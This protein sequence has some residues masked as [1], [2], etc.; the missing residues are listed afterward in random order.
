MMAEHPGPF[1]PRIEADVVTPLSPTYDPRLVAASLAIASFAS[2]VALDLAKRVRGPDRRA[3]LRWWLGGSVAMGLGIWCMHFIGMMAFS[4]PIALG[5]T[6]GLTLASL[7][8]GIGVSAVALFIASR[9]AL[10][11][12]HLAGGALAMGAG[13]CAMHYTGMAAL[14]MAPGIAWNPWLVAASAAIAVAASAVALL[15]FFWLRSV[16]PGRVVVAQAA[17]AFVMGLAICGMHYTGM[18]AA[19][20]PAGSICLSAGALGGSALSTFVVVSS[21]GLLAFT[22]LTSQVDARAQVRTTGLNAQLSLA[23]EQ[24]RQHAFLDALTGLPNRLLFEQR[25]Q[26]ALQHRSGEGATPL[27]ILFID[28]DGFKPVNDLLGHT[29]GDQVLKVVARRLSEAVR[30][31]DTVARVGGDEFVMLL[32]GEAIVADATRAARRLI[33]I[34]ARPFDSGGRRLRLSCSIGIAL[35]PEHGP[36][37]RLLARADAAM[38]AAKRAG[39]NGWALFESQMDT[40]REEH[41]GLQTDLREAIEQRQ[42]ELHYQPKLCARTGEMLGVEALLRWRHPLRGMVS[43]LA[44]IPLAERY[45]L[46]GRIGDWVM[47]EACRQIGRWMADGVR[48]HVA[49]NLSAHQ[50]REDGLVERFRATLE[51]HGVAPELLLCEIT[52]SVAMSDFEATQQAFDGLARAGMMLSIDDFGTGYSSLSYLRRLPAR[53]L[54]IDRSFVADLENSVDARAIVSAVIHLAHDLGLRVVAEGVETE[55]QHEVLVGLECD[56]LQG[57]L[58]AQPMPAAQVLP[59]MRARQGAALV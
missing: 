26:E 4:L 55:G 29:A 43:P 30:A 18:F 34:V 27:A 10:D 37:E 42:L 7:G 31:S 6:A 58:F 46:I 13:I 56:E 53:Q 20:F 36:A 5:Y 45:G 21:I 33:D 1:Q 25:L 23:N 17:A 52:E 50:L 19:A 9:P 38:F 35:H 32:R 2:Y 49:I 59:W 22:L 12:R 44:F 3:A 51:R 15:I 39:G 8:A 48:M 24:L 40:S 54:K 28:L 16:D 47:E 14:D 11:A 41:L 57:Y